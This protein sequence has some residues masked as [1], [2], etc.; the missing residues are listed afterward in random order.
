M[1]GSSLE[2][3]RAKRDRSRTPEPMPHRSGRRRKNRPPA[4]L[5]FVIQEHHAST[6]HWDFRL[7][8]DGVLVSWALPKGL[9]TD[10][11]VNHLAVHT[12][13]H[14]LEYGT[15]SG[16]IPQGEY[17]GGNVIIWDH[18][19]YDCEKWD[20]REVK[21]V[22][23]GERVEGRFVLF[24]TNG[25]SWMIHRMDPVA[26]DF[27]P[28]PRQLSPMLATPGELPAE[29]SGWAY[30]FK[31]DGIRLLVW[32]DG[33]RVRALSRRGNDVTRS[34]PELRALG[35]A[36]GS[37]Q[38]VLDGELVSLDEKGHASFSRLQHRLHV[39]S[40]NDVKR[41]AA[42]FP[43]S[44]VLFDLLHLN[45]LALLGKSYDDRRRLLEGLALNGPHWA[46]TPSFTDITGAEF[47]RI[48]RDM[49]M[50]GVVAKQRES[51]YRPGTRSRDWVK[52]KYERTQEV[53]IGGWTPGDGSRRKLIGSLLVGIP[54]PG[55][56][57]TL[58]YVGKVGTGFTTTAMEELLDDLQPLVRS[59]SPFGRSVP[60][61]IAKGVTWVRPSVVG[62]VRFTEWTADG[63]FR[64][65]VW[66]G[67]RPDTTA[68]EVVREV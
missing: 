26:A 6:L 40:A 44:L 21:V 16:T 9:P 46:T 34:F 5:T 54:V 20:D 52:V 58:D 12:E 7:E 38:M 28:L 24:A 1:S 56:P 11:K 19:T 31:W 63:R 39:T 14:P 25:K 61:D 60:R 4:G 43:V 30:E 2:S 8:H 57:R 3:Y 29:D 66:R 27:E 37:D 59:T 47:L 68:A 36:V 33:G 53:I 10:P 35:E 17:G 32:I 15:F 42:Q 45:G 67:L 62:E 18:G 64:H 49:G 41:V 23:H 48:A 55:H 51:T 22:L 65:P 50:E 13:D